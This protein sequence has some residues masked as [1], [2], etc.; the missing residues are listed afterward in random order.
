[1]NHDENDDFE[2][3]DV[4]YDATAA[5]SG[6]GM[7]ITG[8]FKDGLTGSVMATGNAMNATS[9]KSTGGITT[10]G[11]TEYMPL[12]TDRAGLTPTSSG[13]NGHAAQPGL[14]PYKLGTPTTTTTSGSEGL[15]PP[16]H[17]DSGSS[18]TSSTR[19]MAN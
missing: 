15:V 18:F 4:G 3:M 13:S 17:V 12:Y 11:I 19:G 2:D 7:A 9:G 14:P 5:G 8:T 1:M 16:T 10:G 6:G